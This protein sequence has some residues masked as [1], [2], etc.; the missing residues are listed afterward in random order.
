MYDTLTQ[1][2]LELNLR[3]SHISEVARG[4]RDNVLGFVFYYIDDGKYTMALFNRIARAVSKYYVKIETDE[5]Y[6]E[7]RKKSCYALSQQNKGKKYS[8]EHCRHISQGLIGRKLSPEHIQKIKDRM[9]PFVGKTHT[10]ETRKKL[11]TSKLGDKNPMYDQYGKNAPNSKEVVAYKYPSMEEIGR[12]ESQSQAGEVFGLDF[13]II[14]YHCI[15]HTIHKKSMIGFRFADDVEFKPETK[16]YIVGKYTL[17][18]EHIGTYVSYADAA[19]SVGVTS[20]SI[21][22]CCTGKTKQCKGFVW[23]R[24]N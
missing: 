18:G 22:L 3:I 15:H 13:Q 21:I 6:Y 9:P 7:Q 20:R 2:S 11:S 1:A 24:L 8:K 19:K 17:D 12:F 5:K 14:S 16:I 4:M 23:K 10:P